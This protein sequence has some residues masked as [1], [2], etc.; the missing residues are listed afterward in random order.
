MNTTCTEGPSPSRVKF[1]NTEDL[2]EIEVSHVPPKIT[3]EK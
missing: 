2:A 3:P 1:E